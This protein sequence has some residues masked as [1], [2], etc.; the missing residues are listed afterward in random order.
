MTKKGFTLAEILV[1]LGIIGIVAALTM[2]TLGKSASR[3][4]IG[5][6]LSAA[7]RTIENATQQF[8]ADYNANYLSVA[9]LKSG[10]TGRLDNY[11]DYLVDNGYIKA[12]KASD[13]PTE[14]IP[15]ASSSAADAGLKTSGKGFV[16]ANKS[17]IAA[18]DS[19]CAVL[20]V[21]ATADSGE[22][23]KQDKC[24]IMFMTSGFKNR[25]TLV[26]GLDIFR[27]YLTNDGIVDV[28]GASSCG[29]GKNG[30]DCAG[31][32]AQDGWKVTY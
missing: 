30:S 16:F 5:P 28:G 17:A 32:I 24:E 14:S 18:S 21:A 9:L 3:A 20:T 19:A 10:Q 26:T 31:K 13:I 1:T 12:D 22:V 29:E 8:M 15:Y 4:K 2:P 11:L 25:D 6:E 23:A 7:I 27:F